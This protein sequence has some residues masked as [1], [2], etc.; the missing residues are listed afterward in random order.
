MPGED[1]RLKEDAAYIYRYD[2]EGK[3][4]K[5]AVATVVHNG[6][7]IQDKVSITKPTG[8]NDTTE[9]DTPGPFELQNHGNPVYFRNI[10]VVELK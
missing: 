6:V 3:K 2:K 4:I 1:N 9:K 5:D 7:K 8:G 10:W